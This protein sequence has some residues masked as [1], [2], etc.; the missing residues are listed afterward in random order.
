MPTF[1]S[2]NHGGMTF[3]LFRSAVRTFIDLA[4]GRTSSYVSKDIGATDPGRWHIWQLRC[5]MGAMSLAYVTS[6]VPLAT[7][8]WP[9]RCTGEAMT[10]MAAAAGTATRTADLQRG[11]NVIFF[12]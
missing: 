9:A 7:V 8:C 2:M 3:G 4:Q 11:L 5:R 10:A 1:F 12:L 6:G